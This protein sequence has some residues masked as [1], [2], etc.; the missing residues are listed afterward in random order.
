MSSLLEVKRVYI[1]AGDEIELLRSDLMSKDHKTGPLKQ[2][3]IE[4]SVSE[5]KIEMSHNDKIG[6]ERICCL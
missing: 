3:L 2:V 6:S 5:R 4:I 1:S